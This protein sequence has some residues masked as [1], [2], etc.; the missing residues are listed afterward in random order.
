MKKSELEVGTICTDKTNP[1]KQVRILDIRSHYE[2]N[3]KTYVGHRNYTYVCYYDD[4]VG[5]M[6]LNDFKKQYT[7]NNQ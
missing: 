6:L 4:V 7:I 3:K 2:M 5:H 1:H